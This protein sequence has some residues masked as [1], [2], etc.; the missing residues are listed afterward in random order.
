MALQPGTRLGAYEILGFVGAGG[1][2]EVYRARDP[3]LGR[4]IAIKV[5]PADR[6]ADED[7][8]RRFVQEAQAASALNHPHIITIYE[9]DTAEVNDFIVMEF[10][11]GKSLDALIPRQGMRL[12]DA[13]RIAIPVADALAAAHARGIIH[14]DLKP[15]NVIVGTDG[16]VKVLDFGLAKLVGND[17]DLGAETPTVT[18]HAALS[19]P[20]TLAGTAAYMSPE[21][22][23][24]GPV[25]ARSDIF[26]FGAM[27]YEMVTGTRAFAGTSTADTL[28]AVI[29]AQ[30]Q[31][32]SAIIAA[33]P[34]DLEKLIL[35]CLRKDPQRRFQHIDDVK[36][37][38]QD[39]KEE[40][41]S[42][43]R[44]AAPAARARRRGLVV[45]LAVT[46]MLGSAGTAWVLRS[47]R[48]AAVPPLHVVSLT[49]LRGEEHQPTFSPDGEQ[50]AFTW[51][52]PKQDNWDIYVTLVGSSNVR[53]LTSDPSPDN[54][55]EWSPDGRQIAFLRERADGSTI[56]LVSALG[57]ED[58]KLSDFRGAD[59]LGWS[60]DGQWVV[61][62]RA[63]D[64][65]YMAAGQ[66]RGIYL[67]P[68]EGGEARPLI[69]SGPDAADYDPAFA[70]DGRRLAYASC[71]RASPGGIARFCDM[72]LVELDAAHTPSMP[73]RRLTT[74]RS[75][76]IESPTWTRDGSAVVYAAAAPEMNL[77]RVE[78]AG[79]RSPERIEVAGVGAFS[80]A[81]APSR[82]RLAFT[83][84]SVDTD[85]YR[86]DVGRPVQLVFGSSGEETDARL[87]PDGRR[88]VFGSG[89]SDAPEEIW[90]A[91]ADGSNPQ[92]LTHGPGR[93]QGSPSWSPDGRRIVFDSLA[94]DAH[95]HLWVIDA[96]GGPPRRLTTQAGDEH[97]PSWSRDGRWIYFSSDQGAAARDLW[98]VSADGKTS[99][100]LIREANGAFAC[101]SNDG[102]NLLFQPR[103][104]DSPLMAMPPAGGGARQ[105]VACVKNSA[106]G[107]GP[108]GVY[109]AACDPSS[110]PPL[111]VLDLETGRDRLLGT[112]EGL[113][114]RPLGLAVSPDGKTIVYPR[115]MHIDA[116]LML[117]EN[118]R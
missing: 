49:T 2:G 21:Q 94:D 76:N 78:V 45:A 112:L 98:R 40:S 39:I 75:L 58:R 100:R 44:A 52:G 32:P 4:E 43:A 88:L 28:S 74:Q 23:T 107:A 90:V 64:L 109:Y 65:D 82:E 89:R 104:A 55:P 101:E 16:A 57:G 80:P 56:Q 24:G 103:D 116:D 114:D 63:D 60:P 86:F 84:L 27:L 91:E 79:T 26:S 62:G 51:N 41:D 14:R 77:W 12:S 72:Y 73:S 105:L 10:V 95:L 18:G 106:F 85:L 87:S 47:H 5:L 69:A 66:P 20:G 110:N 15:A 59:S 99:E 34:S 22:A 38:L 54:K 50:V 37:A 71:S 11:R 42:D 1:M 31:A 117:I 70:P 3:R 81:I 25:D 93:A 92:P 67:I 111:H 35:R 83:R 7:R 108:Q 9:I 33:V 97:T 29:R 17:E 48:A 115:T 96:D 8:R 36:I 13:L 19:A 53:R 61:A 6:V 113:M 68:V 30:P 46:V 118:Y 102:K